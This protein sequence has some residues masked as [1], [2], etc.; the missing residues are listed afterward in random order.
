MEIQD[1]AGIH[2]GETCVLIGN[3][4]SQRNINLDKLGHLPTFAVNQIY[5]VYDDTDWRPTYFGMMHKKPGERWKMEAIRQNVDKSII[6]TD[7]NFPL[8]NPSVN[9]ITLTGLGRLMDSLASNVILNQCEDYARMVARDLFS[10]DLPRGYYSFHSEYIMAQLIAYMGFDEVFLIGFDPLLIQNQIVDFS[11][12]LD[13]SEYNDRMEYLMD[14]LRVGAPQDVK[15]GILWTL[16]RRFP[17]LYQMVAK[18]QSYF[19]D[20]YEHEPKS[21]ME[22]HEHLMSH[23]I[24]SKAFEMRSIEAYHVHSEG[25]DC[26]QSV[27]PHEF[28][29]I[30]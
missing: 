24:I 9:I 20:Q 13:P 16:S 8:S 28:E 15:N 19:H 18:E 11:G 21:A 7:T 4:P 30:I 2:D 5:H 29:D 10:D 14:T 25:I 26:Y 27:D 22:K 6:F 12:K 17:K 3:G 23:L 1:F